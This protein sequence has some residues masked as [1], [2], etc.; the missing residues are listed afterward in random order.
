M[1]RKY[2]SGYSMDASQF[3]YF[4]GRP[5]IAMV[6]HDERVNLKAVQEVHDDAA[7]STGDRDIFLLDYLLPGS[8]G[9]DGVGVSSLRAGRT[10]SSSSPV[11]ADGPHDAAGGAAGSNAQ[12]RRA[13]LS[14]R[15]RFTPACRPSC[16]GRSQTGRDS[17]TPYRR[18]RASDL[19]VVSMTERPPHIPARSSTTD[20]DQSAG[21]FSRALW[22]TAPSP[23][24]DAG[25][26]RP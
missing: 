24:S 8:G 14:N 6:A 23:S 15:G 11:R 7:S 1:R 2:T 10:R 26:R 9:G 21:L 12:R 20:Y 18:S 17:K 13:G 5:I 19:A 4:S 25:Y 22:A 3:I 16:S